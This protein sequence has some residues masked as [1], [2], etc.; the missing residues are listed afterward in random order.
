MAITGN[1]F[2]DRVLSNLPY[3]LI[4][5]VGPGIAAGRIIS[6]AGQPEAK[7]KPEPPAAPPVP[8]AASSGETIPPLGGSAGG[9]DAGTPDLPT[10]QDLPQGAPSMGSV[11]DIF[12]AILK[13]QA[14]EQAA[15]RKFYPERAATDYEYWQK[16][17][18]IARQNA[19][20]R[21]AEKTRRDVELQ[22]I[23]AW[24]KVTSAGIN[25]DALLATGMMQLS[26]TLGMPNP[27][28]LNATAGLAQQAAAAF[29]PGQPVF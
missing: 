18:E 11:Q 22:T 28:V 13:Q 5:A 24:Q 12:T 16:R 2:L 1:E 6:G 29:K 17:E 8:P 14:A 23:D 20:E 27:N 4:P 19:L 10:Q 7:K 15:A 3:A 25:R 9:V 21:M 26:A